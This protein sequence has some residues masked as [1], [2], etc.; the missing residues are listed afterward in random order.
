MGTPRSVIHLPH[1]ARLEFEREEHSLLAP[2]T[3]TTIVSPI[4]GEGE[5]GHV[6]KLGHGEGKVLERGG[7]TETR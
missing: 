6:D 7:R 4:G 1:A 2:Y 5:R 3:D